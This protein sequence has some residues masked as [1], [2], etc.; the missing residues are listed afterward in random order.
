MERVEKVKKVVV[1]YFF[2][3]P[4]VVN[5]LAC[6]ICLGIHSGNV[7][8]MFIFACHSVL[9][10]TLHL[11]LELFPQKVVLFDLAILFC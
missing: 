10:Y 9:L 4:E 1:L 6:S 3:L 11:L 7:A 2:Y 5:C 8:E